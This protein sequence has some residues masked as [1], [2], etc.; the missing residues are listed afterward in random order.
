VIRPKKNKYT[1]WRKRG[2]NRFEKLAVT[3]ADRTSM[4]GQLT[5]RLISKITVKCRSIG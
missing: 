5:D 4:T 2:Q 3:V 1:R